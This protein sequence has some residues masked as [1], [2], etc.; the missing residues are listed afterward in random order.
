[1]IVGI[2]V[3]RNDAAVGRLGD[4]HAFLRVVVVLQA[5][6]VEE[7]GVFHANRRI[8]CRKGLDGREVSVGTDRV[9]LEAAAWHA[10]LDG[11]EDV[12]PR[13]HG[14]TTRQKLE[15]RQ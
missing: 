6:A 12:P 9:V 7:N 11:V 8:V 15:R 5:L 1:M 2:A 10:I 14:D 4:L 3:E 13:P